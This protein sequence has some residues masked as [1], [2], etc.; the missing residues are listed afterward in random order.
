MRYVLSIAAIFLVGSFVRAELLALDLTIVKTK[1]GGWSYRTSDPKELASD[2]EL[3]KY[4]KELSNPKDGIWLTIQSESDVPIDQ[5][6]KI[7]AMVKAN[8]QGIVIKRIVLDSKRFDRP[9]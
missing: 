7:L 4:L 6:T 3:A 2:A 1:S 9:K 8:P 5:L